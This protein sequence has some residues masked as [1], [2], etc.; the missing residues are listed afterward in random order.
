MVARDMLRITEAYGRE[1]LLYYGGSYGT[2]LGLTFAYMFPDKVERLVIDSAESMNDWYKTDWR[3]I[4]DD[5]DKVLLAAA[6]AC[7]KSSQCALHANSSGDVLQRIE[8]TM[9]LLYADPI[10]VMID[11][12]RYG[13]A[14]FGTARAAL[15]Q[16]T[17]A[18]ERRFSSFARALA[19]VE[20]GNGALLYEIAG[21]DNSQW[22][23]DD[24][25]PGSSTLDDAE[26]MNYAVICGDGEPGPSN[27]DEARQAYADMAVR[28][29]FADVMTV[30]ARC[31]G[32]RIRAKERLKGPFSANTSFPILLLTNGADPVGPWKNVVEIEQNFTS[33]A[34]KQTGVGHCVLPRLSACTARHVRAYFRDGVLPDK[35]TVCEADHTIFPP[36]EEHVSSRNHLSPEDTEL[37]EMVRGMPDLQHFFRL[38]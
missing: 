17:Y 31:A 5:A 28:G 29:S 1:R 15:L 38:F 32:W 11:E 18:P 36:E 6:D 7:A 35:G 20:A 3:F 22:R 16:M 23:C 14:D 27:V 9:R 13:L 4:V 37:M 10:P 26:L 34:L 30:P 8:S 21:R 2:I 12:H 19:A 24:N 33:V 25:T